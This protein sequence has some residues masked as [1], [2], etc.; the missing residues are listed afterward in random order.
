MSN[1]TNVDIYQIEYLKSPSPAL[2]HNIENY[3]IKGIFTNKQ[4][5]IIIC[6]YISNHIILFMHNHN[7]NHSESFEIHVLD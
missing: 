5:F 4:L 3:N 6:E 7:I 1:S 2:K